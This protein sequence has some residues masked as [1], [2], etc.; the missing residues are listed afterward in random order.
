MPMYVGMH[1]VC[2]GHRLRGLPQSLQCQMGLQKLKYTHCYQ[3]LRLAVSAM[4]APV[5]KQ[6]LTIQ[7]QTP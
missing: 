3:G 7:G 2:G 5:I 1:G 6:S 4:G